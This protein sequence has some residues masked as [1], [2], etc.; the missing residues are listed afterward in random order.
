MHL[1]RFIREQSNI[2]NQYDKVCREINTLGIEDAHLAEY[3]HK[4]DSKI[5]TC[6]CLLPEHATY[7][8]TGDNRQIRIDLRKFEREKL[9]VYALSSEVH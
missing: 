7:L 2:E 9:E 5:D 3:C 8:E 1:S 4:L 6:E